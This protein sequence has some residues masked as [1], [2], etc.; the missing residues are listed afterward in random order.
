M[1]IGKDALR[2]TLGADRRDQY[3]KGES[4][5]RTGSGGR[6]RT[7]NADGRREEGE[8]G[9][10]ATTAMAHVPRRALAHGGE[11]IPFYWRNSEAGGRSTTECSRL[12]RSRPAHRYPG[13]GRRR[14][15]AFFSTVASERGTR[16]AYWV[17][18]NQVVDR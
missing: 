16:S 6:T 1:V 9:G 12:R 7:A 17:N 2:G 10:V 3:V 15:G 4:S 5:K 18:T 13:R 8:V 14:L 11:P